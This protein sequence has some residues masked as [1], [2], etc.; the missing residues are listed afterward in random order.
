MFTKI[1][2]WTWGGISSPS[3]FPVLPS[4]MCDVA[5]YWLSIGERHQ[6]YAACQIKSCSFG[7]VSSFSSTPSIL[8]VFLLPKKSHYW[9]YTSTGILV[10]TQKIN[11]IIWKKNITASLKTNNNFFLNLFAKNNTCIRRQFGV[12]NL[13]SRPTNFSFYYFLHRTVLI[14]FLSKRWTQKNENLSVL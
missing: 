10:G 8:I 4:T 12:L 13:P 11:W 5:K 6:T 14:L 7:K 3:H 1:Y 9:N 2:Q